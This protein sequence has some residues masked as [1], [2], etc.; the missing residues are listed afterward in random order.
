MVQS[1]A[2]AEQTAEQ[3]AELFGFLAASGD[4]PADARQRLARAIAQTSREA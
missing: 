1:P 4:L 2:L 3:T